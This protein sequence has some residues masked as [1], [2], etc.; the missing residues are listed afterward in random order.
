MRH[1]LN[2]LLNR[3]INEL[4]NF[5]GS[6]S[7]IIIHLVFLISWLVLAL[8]RDILIFI[9][10][11]ESVFIW[12]FVIHTTNKIRDFEWKRDRFER[13]RDREKL[14]SEI[15]ITEK[16]LRMT[17]EVYKVVQDLSR[18]VMEIKARVTSVLPLENAPL[19]TVTD[20]ENDQGNS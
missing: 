2:G 10:A 18:D 8:P 12:F 1:S 16:D 20:N 13:K 3:S 9:F 11:I 17:Q 19:K 15:S 6:P 5:L 7:S 4:T 14:E